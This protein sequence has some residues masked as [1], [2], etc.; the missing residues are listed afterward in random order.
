M[1]CDVQY[2][3]F[4]LN[5]LSEFDLSRVKDVTLSIRTPSE[6]RQ[7]LR[8][9]AGREHRPS[10]SMLEVLVLEKAREH[11]LQ[12]VGPETS[13]ID[14]QSFELKRKQDGGHKAAE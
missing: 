5:W 13:I 8:L 1:E 14:T 4:A 6:L 11:Q 9:A 7:L 10:A 12:P 2:G 3:T